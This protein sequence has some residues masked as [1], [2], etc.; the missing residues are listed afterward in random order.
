MIEKNKVEQ[1]AFELKTSLQEIKMKN[2]TEIRKLSSFD[3]ETNF[4]K[5]QLSGEVKKVTAL[6]K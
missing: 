2:Q 4:L 3:Q 6:V 5:N 1:E